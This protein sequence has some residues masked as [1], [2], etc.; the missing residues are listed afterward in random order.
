MAKLSSLQLMLETSLSNDLTKHVPAFAVQKAKNANKDVTAVMKSAAA[1]VQK[2]S[3]SF[4]HTMD[5][6]NT[7][8]ME[9]VSANRLLSNLLHT[10]STHAV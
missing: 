6:I 7:I 8:A 9:A 3:S 10:V 4:N 1:V 5:D 2:S